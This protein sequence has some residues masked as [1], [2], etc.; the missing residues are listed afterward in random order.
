MVTASPV[1]FARIEQW[2]PTRVTYRVL[3]FVLA[4]ALVAIALLPDGTPALGVLAFG[5][6]GPGCSAL[7]PLTISFGQEQL[8]VMSASVAGG[9]IACYQLGYGIAAFGPVPSRTP[10]SAC[11]PSLGAPRWRSW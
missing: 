11:R 4:A 7:L 8:V 5:L 1:L 2:L 6:A 3:P 9:V 10:V